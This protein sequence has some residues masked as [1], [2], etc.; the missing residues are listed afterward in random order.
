MTRRTRTGRPCSSASRRASAATGECSFPPKA[1]PL[2]ER[3]G[4]LAAGRAPRGVGL[5]IGGLD[6]GRPQASSAHSPRGTSTGWPTGAAAAALDLAGS[7]RRALAQGLGR[8]PTRRVVRRR[9]RAHRRRARCRRR[10]RPRPSD[11]GGPT[12]CGQPPRAAARHAAAA[13]GSPASPPGR[14][15][16]GRRPPGREA[17]AASRMLLPPGAPAQVGG[18]APSHAASSTGRPVR[19]LERG[20]PHDDARACRSRTGWPRRRRRRRP[21]ARRT[22]GSGP[23]ASSPPA[24]RPGGPGSR[25]RRG[26]APST[27]TVQQPHWPWGL[28]PSLS[29]RHPSRSRS[30]SRSELPSSSRRRPSTWPDGRAQ[31]RRRR[32]SGP[33]RQR[34]S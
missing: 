21:S 20:Q 6:P 15:A 23:R 24:R 34:L 32:R 31:R 14:R 12:A 2:A 19:A 8:P 29:D 1:P 11:A 26:A 25:R 30:T 4:R 9:R 16:A 33:R 17:R 5:E 18:R 10:T 7:A 13:V 28:Q 22:A 3:R 27:Q